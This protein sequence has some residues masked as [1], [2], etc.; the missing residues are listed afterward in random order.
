MND[1]FIGMAPIDYSMGCSQSSKVDNS[2]SNAHLVSI[3]FAVLL[4]T[5]VLVI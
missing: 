5:P 2:I 1:I 4:K 3:V